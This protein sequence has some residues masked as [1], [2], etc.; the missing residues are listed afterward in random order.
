MIINRMNGFSIKC[1]N[2]HCKCDYFIDAGLN[3]DKK[4]WVELLR[5]ADW[6]INTFEGQHY[7]PDHNKT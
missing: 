1:D 7:C 5:K 2:P 4:N 3:Y 6:H